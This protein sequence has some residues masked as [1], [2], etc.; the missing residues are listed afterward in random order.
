M[1]AIVLTKYGSPSMLQ[2]QELPKP[3]PQENE[4][5]VKIH[6]TAINDYD[7][8]MVRGKPHLYRLMFGLLKPKI[9]IPGM[10]L[11]GTIE[12]L[13]KNVQSFKLGDVVY[14]DIS[15]YGFGSFAEY[16]CIHEKALALKPPKMTFEEAA[17]IPHA[18]LLAYQGLIDLGKIQNGQQ[19][20]INGAGG[21]VGTFGLQLAK[22]YDAEVTGVEAFHLIPN[23]ILKLDFARALF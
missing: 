6:A 15:D 1:K 21:G 17:A 13:G 11:S 5:L 4:V 14:G 9:K 23:G 10:E 19:I 2:L 20:L 18:S 16:I 12:A 22:L 8:S 3:V 7:W